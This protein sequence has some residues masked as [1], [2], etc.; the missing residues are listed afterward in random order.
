MR[1]DTPQGKK[2]KKAYKTVQKIA[3][4]VVSFL[5]FTTKLRHRFSAL[6]SELQLH[7]KSEVSETEERKNAQVMTKSVVII[8]SLFFITPP[9]RR[10]DRQHPKAQREGGHR[11]EELLQRHHPQ[12]P[13]HDQHA[14]G[15]DQGAI[16]SSSSRLG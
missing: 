7:L 3:L 16:S 13:G 14:Q 4:V 5:I 15:G 6:R 8:T 2:I 11:H 1:D 10:S 12:Q 9:H